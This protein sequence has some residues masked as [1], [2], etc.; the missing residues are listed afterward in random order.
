MSFGTA[1]LYFFY[2]P[3]ASSPPSAGAFGAGAVECDAGTYGSLAV[4]TA[5]FG[6][7]PDLWV[8]T[9]T[10]LGGG[11]YDWQEI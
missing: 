1:G 7:R 11:D 6:T 8:C 9:F 10:A 5:Q 2:F 3:T 4:N